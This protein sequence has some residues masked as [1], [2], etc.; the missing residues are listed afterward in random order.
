MHFTAK[1]QRRKEGLPGVRQAGLLCV[2]AVKSQRP[3]LLL[4]SSLDCCDLLQSLL[5]YRQDTL[6]RDLN[7]V[8]RFSAVHRF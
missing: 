7:V 5:L 2:S 8:H 1:A 4:P 6:T 3:K